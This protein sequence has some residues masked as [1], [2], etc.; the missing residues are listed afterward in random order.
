MTSPDPVLCRHRRT[1]WLPEEQTLWIPIASVHTA[2]GYGY[3]PHPMSRRDWDLWSMVNDAR[4]VSDIARRMGISDD[5]VR[6]WANPLAA[7]DC[8]ALVFRD[9]PPRPTDFGL[10]RL[11]GAQRDRNTRPE[12]QHGEFGETTLSNYHLNDVVDGNT[13]FDNR[14]TT[15]A[16]AQ[17]LPHPALQGTRFGAR[18]LQFLSPK[19]GAR[20]LE[21]GGGTGELMAAWVEA[22]GPVPIRCDLSPTLLA[23]QAK[24]IPAS[25]GVVADCTQMPLADASVDM[26]VCNEVIADLSAVPFDGKDGGGAVHEV[27]QRLRRYRLPQLPGDGPYNLG[28][29][30]L[31][32]EV[33]RVLRPGGRAWISEFGDPHGDASASPVEATQLD[34]PEVSIHFGYLAHIAGC[35]GLEVELVRMDDAL[36][37]DM[38][39][40]Q[41]WRGSYQALRALCRA[42]D[43]HLEARAWTEA[44]LSQAL[45]WK[46]EGLQW[47]PMTDEGPGPLVTRFWALVLR[48]SG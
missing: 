29:W 25:P 36:G 30:K 40:R 19:V 41:L 44:S 23:T 47:V 26:V 3:R 45:Q 38:A 48:Y 7:E 32:E 17:G 27:A 43:V 16:H 4:R 18:L 10:R 6:S 46:V 35:L 22:G 9:T 14:E 15:V 1:L 21:I 8:Q 11:Q 31:V 12:D 37:F 13:H 33:A 28:A 34:H 5:D 24:R 2:G 42:R 39:A 20:V